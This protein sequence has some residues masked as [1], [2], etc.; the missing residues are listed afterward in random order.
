MLTETIDDILGHYFTQTTWS[1]FFGPSGY[2]NT[3]RYVNVGMNTYLLRVYETHNDEAKV[4]FEHEVLSKLNKF[5]KPYFQIP[6]PLFTLN[7]ETTYVR[8][9]DTNKIACVYTFIE[10]KNPLLQNESLLISYGQ[11][12]GHLVGLLKDT[13]IEQPCSY[14]PYYEIGEAYKHYSIDSVINWCTD[15][16]STFITIEDELK[17]IAEQFLNLQHSLS[18][19][20]SLPHQLIHGDINA[21]NSLAESN[22]I[23]AFLDFE[24][25]TYDL[26]AMEPAVCLAELFVDVKGIDMEKAKAFIS[27]F[28]SVVTLSN[29]EIE[30]IPLL[31]QLRRL[32]VFVHFLN[33]YCE[34]VNNESILY[35]QI[36]KTASIK[37]TSDEDRNLISFWKNAQINETLGKNS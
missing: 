17:W 12:V 20:K 11:Q 10:G 24:F 13:L 21:S 5:A 36:V 8:T 25:A 32:D 16:P 35:E 1:V 19:L 29:A 15:P 27:G 31:I 7:G 34:G 3:T 14:K 26:R 22:R 18:Q 9:K 28:S 6:V 2:N 33:Q 4:K 37:Q 30:A 23:T